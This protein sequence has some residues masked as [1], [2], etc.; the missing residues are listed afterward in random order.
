MG[1]TAT[2]CIAYGIV[3]PEDWLYNNLKDKDIWEYFDSKYDIDL[4]VLGYSDSK[5]YA[6]IV[7]GS[8]KSVDW[9]D[10]LDLSFKDFLQIK[11]EKFLTWLKV[12]GI[13]DTPTWVLYAYYG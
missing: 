13:D 8:C 11:P 3:L 5:H 1:M 4:E 10:T 6:L 9:Y 7:P 12:L 2:A